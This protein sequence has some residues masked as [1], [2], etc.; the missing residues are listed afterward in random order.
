M[1]F[2]DAQKGLFLSFET[3]QIQNINHC[4]SL[5]IRRFFDGGLSP[6]DRFRFLDKSIS[7]ANEVPLVC[8]SYRNSSH[9]RA[10]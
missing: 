1:L 6:F 8:L 9:I 3:F 7:S 2:T 4:L 10:E 5:S